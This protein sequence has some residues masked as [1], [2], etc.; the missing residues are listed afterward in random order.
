MREYLKKL[1]SEKN[2]SQTDV[3]NTL[4]CAK[5][6]YCLVEAGKRQEKMTV[7][8]LGRLAKVLNV[9]A[10]ELLKLETEYSET[11]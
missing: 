11:K 9:P 6:T 7:E 10:E 5:S 2:L 1:R 4:G 3:A 8:F